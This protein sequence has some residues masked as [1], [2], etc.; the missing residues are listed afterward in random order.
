[1]SL[2]PQA[3]QLIE[4]KRHED[5]RG[6]FV[7]S[8]S[9]RDAATRGITERFVQDN[10]SLSRPA[11]TLR[12]LHF[13]VEPHAQSKLVRCI[14][15]RIWDVVVDIRS[16]SPG[17]GRSQAW[18][19]SAENGHQLYIPAGFAHGFLTLEPDCEIA[20]KV[21]ALYSGAHDRGIR[22]DDPALGIEW[23]MPA[24][25]VPLVSLKDE[26]LPTLATFDALQAAG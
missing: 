14:R 25:I 18:E 13:Q 21:S 1:M 3:P 9:E 22:W 5:E 2:F 8:Y 23:P 20:Y 6:W 26:A 15:G 24:G 12:G 19:L 7:E 16:G 11:F 17:R 10:H 4:P